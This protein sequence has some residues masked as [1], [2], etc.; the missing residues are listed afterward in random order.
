MPQIQTNSGQMKI[1]LAMLT[2]EL[3]YWHIW[4]ILSSLKRFAKASHFL[5]DPS[6]KIEQK[7][8]I[9]PIDGLS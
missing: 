8:N 3:D 6:I 9:A 2:L 1:Y 7:Y 4:K 5:F